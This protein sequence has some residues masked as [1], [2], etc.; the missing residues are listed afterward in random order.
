MPPLSLDT[1]NTMRV[2]IA[3]RDSM[4]GDLL[5]NAL[6]RNAEIEAISIH[7][8]EL[9]ERLAAGE[10]GL[11]VISSDIEFETG[12]GFELA[13][14]V[15]R[16]YPDVPVLILLN[17]SSHEQV[18]RSFRAGARGVFSRQ[19]PMAEFLECVRHMGRGFLWAGK[20]E[21]NN[22]REALQSLPGT[23]A[24][25]SIQASQL[26]ARELQV[27]QLVAT[28]MTNKAI[29]GELVLSEHT[30]KNYLFRAFDKLGVSSRME[31]LLQ[32]TGRT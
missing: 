10:F 4:G 19:R 5:A 15:S 6:S 2:V 23:M 14:R 3:D 22:L 17:H 13:D 16:S 29:A 7:P 30:V 31:L 28:G 1:K 26:T 12:S 21:T 24:S 20:Q 11:V 25:P 8:L 18:L 9:L 32:M 27:V